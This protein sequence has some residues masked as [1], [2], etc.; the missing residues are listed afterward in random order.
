MPI[1]P[2][3][4]SNV[5]IMSTKKYDHLFKNNGEG[6]AFFRLCKPHGHSVEVKSIDMKYW[7]VYTPPDGVRIAVEPMTFFGNMYALY[8]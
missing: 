6:E 2:L 7:Q 8:S 3:I 5:E 4:E 1:V